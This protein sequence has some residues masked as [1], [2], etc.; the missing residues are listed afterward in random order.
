MTSRG[1][2]RRVDVARALRTLLLVCVLFLLV[3]G[4]GGG[5]ARSGGGRATIAGTAGGETIAD[6]EATA[7]VTDAAARA[8]ASGAEARTGG[9]AVRTGGEGEARSTAGED[10]AAQ[11]EEA[12]LRFGGDRGTAFSGECDIGDRS[13]SLEGRVPER[14][15][16]QLDGRDVKCEIRKE[17]RGTLRVEFVAGDDRYVQS[18]GGRWVLMNFAYSG[19]G[20]SSSVNS[21]TVSGSSSQ[22]IVSSGSSFSE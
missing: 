1:R 21:A 12:T 13:E 2:G 7:R 22:S 19:R 5:E 4:C 14:V 6:R 20:F 10:G 18:T 8:G 11:P 3:A 15:V 16:F 9:A 17:S